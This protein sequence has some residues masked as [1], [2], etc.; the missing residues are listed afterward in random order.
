[1]RLP[2]ATVKF[3]TPQPCP[4]ARVP[5]CAS[6]RQAIQIASF[7]AS[8]SDAAVVLVVA[9]VVKFKC[10]VRRF[11]APA[12]P[13]L[14]KFI[15]LINNPSLLHDIEFTFEEISHPEP[16]FSKPEHCQRW[17]GAIAPCLKYGRMAV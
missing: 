9:S 12:Y 4:Y 16:Y 11:F 17:R 1:M 3:I 14:D 2:I 7:D 5:L 6:E 10:W 8:E 13:G 15:Q